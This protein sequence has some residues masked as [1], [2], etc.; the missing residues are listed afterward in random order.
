MLKL[1]VG[2][3]M[4]AIETEALVAL[5]QRL[6][7][8]EDRLAICQ[9]EGAYSSAHDG[10]K[11]DDWAAL[12]T[13]D[14]I[15]QGRQLEG[16][17]ELNFVQ[18]RKALSEFC[19]SSPVNCIH[20]LNVPDITIGGDDATARINFTFRAFGVDSFGRV[21][22]TEAQGY[23]DVA[24]KRTSDGWRIRRRFTVYFERS[25]KTAYGYEPSAAP[26]GDSNPPL[27]DKAVFR[28]RR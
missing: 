1:V 12:F 21:N 28:D 9:I 13:E 2:K 26:F 22:G 6:R 4:D 25:Q 14:G 23:Y 7:A 20:Y 5:E 11:G 15:Y 8:V 19:N 3:D 10:A 16:M 27:D 17:S 18:G 24:Y